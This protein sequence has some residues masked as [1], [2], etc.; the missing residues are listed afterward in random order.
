MVVSTF[1]YGLLITILGVISYFATGQVS[2][3]ALIPCW[4]GLP[5]IFL[6][7]TAWLKPKITKKVMIAALIIAFLALGGTIRGFGG[8]L[9]LITGGEVARPAATIAQFI[10]AIASLGYIFISGFNLSKQNKKS[11]N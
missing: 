8:F 2:K 11:K 1:L 5:I 7:F 3:T 9:T 4:F 10:M 6:A